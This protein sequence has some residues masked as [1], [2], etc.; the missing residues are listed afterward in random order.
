VRAI[1][2]FGRP[3]WYVHDWGG[4]PGILLRSI[5]TAVGVAGAPAVLIAWE[6]PLRW[7]S[8]GGRK[9]TTQTIAW[10][11]W[12]SGLCAGAA[13]SHN[14]D[15]VLFEPSDW[16][17]AYTLEGGGTLQG[18]GKAAHVA[19]ARELAPDVVYV[20]PRGALRDGR[21]DAVLL[22]QLVS[23]TDTRGLK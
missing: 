9:T 21:A 7:I 19:L 11:N 18:Q 23:L 6:R 5:K 12:L 8:G 10:M 15:F 20:G 14:V 16:T 4:E 22:A 13:M 1:D 17:R 3:S 2:E